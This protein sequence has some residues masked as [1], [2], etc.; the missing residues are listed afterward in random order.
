MAT[1]RGFARVQER[2]AARTAAIIWERRSLEAD[3]AGPGFGV[4]WYG[5]LLGIRQAPR[6][7]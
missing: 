2:A 7:R 1:M 3:Q 6:V 4:R 5:G